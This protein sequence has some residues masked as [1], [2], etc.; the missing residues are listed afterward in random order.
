MIQCVV[1]GQKGV[2]V[3]KKSVKLK[4]D[5]ILVGSDFS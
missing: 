1:Y 2:V 5:K 4:I 3:M